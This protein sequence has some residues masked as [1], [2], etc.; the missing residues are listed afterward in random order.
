MK[1]YQCGSLTLSSVLLAVATLTGIAGAQ[2]PARTVP[3]PLAGHP[4]HV[5]LAGEEVVL[6]LPAG[7][8]G[9][10]QLCDYEGRSLASPSAVQGRLALGRLPVGYYQLQREQ[11]IV[12]LAVLAPLKAPTPPS[13]PIALDVAM[14]WFYPE[15]KMEAVSSL[16]ALAGVNQVRD[17]LTWGEVETAKGRF[18]AQTKYD[19][20][21]RAQSRAGL[22]VLQVAHRSPGWATRATGRFPPD[23]RDAHNFYREVARRWR[24]EVPAFEPWNEA[25]IIQFGGHTGSEMAAMQKA[26]WLGLKAGNPEVTACLNVFAMHNQAQLED[27]RDNETW[28]Y[29]D[30]FNLHH[31]APFDEYPRLYADFRAVSAGR[32]LWVSECALPVKWSGDS[33]LQ[34]PTEADAR[35][36]AERATKVF[37]CSLHEGSAATFYFLLPHYVEGQ[38]QFGLLR[39]DLSPRPGYVA[40]AAVGRLLADAKP[41][42]RLKGAA[43]AVRGFLFAARPDGEAADVLVAWTTRGNAELALPLSPAR[44]SDHLGR[45][46][47]P[48]S[49]LQL[50]PAPLIALFPAGTSKRFALDPSPAAPPRLPGTPCPVVLQPLWPEDRI[51]LS[52]SAY[53]VS[54]DKP[55]RVPLFVY[56]FG[57]TPVSGRLAA[58]APPGCRVGSLPAL[59]RLAPQSRTELALTM[60][61]AEATSARLTETVRVTGDFGPAGRPVLAFRI[62]PDP[63][64]LTRQAGLPIGGASDPARWQA[65]VSGDGSANVAVG[66]GTVVIEA[67]PQ[68]S[69]KWVYPKLTLLAD[70]H[71]PEGTVGLCCTLQVLEGEGQFRAIF[72]EANGSSYVTDF[73]ARPKAGERVEALALFENV[74]FGTGWSKPDPNGRLD[75]GQVVSVKIGCNAKTARVKFSLG[76]L[77]WIKP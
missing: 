53:R 62:M 10:W 11:E 12:S 32:P 49:S 76:R 37:A 57:D 74:S 66:D 65:T 40:L 23:L 20:S 21:A 25:D 36:L 41:L 68:G 9:P 28:P 16:C 51:V 19:T 22:R 56:N 39:K 58:S 14:A 50:S 31:Y 43:E 46:R 24:G 71:P 69:D 52:R 45:S 18:V 67:A 8:S 63:P 75:V 35:L 77:R 38:T 54:A 70:G 34:E 1:P 47:E 61:C 13:S 33:G 55:E 27:L 3:S 48:A 5:F 73:V 72:D 42:G 26:S 7:N 17:R 15:E 29:F 4:G 6:A 44:L 30:T 59:E 2:E 64:L 60:D